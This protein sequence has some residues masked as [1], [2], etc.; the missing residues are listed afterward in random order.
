MSNEFRMGKP[1]PIY[2]SRYVPKGRLNVPFDEPLTPGLRK[3]KEKTEAI[4]FVHHFD[5]DIYGDFP[6]QELY[7][8]RGDK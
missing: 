3:R 7:Y 1:K 5:P 8:K 6:G 2:R 4:G